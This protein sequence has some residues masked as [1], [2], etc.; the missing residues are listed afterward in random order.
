[1]NSVCVRV[2][3]TGPVQYY[4]LAVSLNIDSSSSIFFFTGK[5]FKQLFHLFF[6][7]LRTATGEYNATS[8]FG[9][10]LA[11]VQLLSLESNQMFPQKKKTSINAERTISL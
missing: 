7:Y 6:S 8:C 3:P 5:R 4:S 1:M 2:N 11:G 10:V 9:S